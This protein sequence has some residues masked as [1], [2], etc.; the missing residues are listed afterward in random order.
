MSVVLAALDTTAAARPVLET[1][2]RI[3]ELFGA[4][5]EVLHVRSS[6]EGSFETPES[7]AARSGLPF[8]LLEDPVEAALLG[9]IGSSEV[10]AA[11]IGARSTTSGRRPVGRTARHILEHTDKP[12]VV[13][14]PEVSSPQKFRRLLVPLEGTETSS[15]PVLEWLWPLL[16]TDV[17]LFVLHVFTDATLPA[18]LDRP[19]RDTEALGREFLTRH[20]P[21]A[22]YIELRTG[23]VAARVAD[24]S[25]EHGADLI[26]LS[27][28]QSSSGGRAGV[29]REVLGAASCP[30]LLLPVARSDTDDA[31]R[32]L[33]GDE[34]REE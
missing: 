8:R 6:P 14:P 34:V 13:V 26:V 2:V 15:R 25:R 20:L 31:N 32:A 4:A 7:L 1:A 18:M 23:P 17:Q 10:L 24:M 5:V 3:G 29:V 12:V 19:V 28:S 11:V 27:W 21:H 33:T 16:V 30:V 9:A 22:N